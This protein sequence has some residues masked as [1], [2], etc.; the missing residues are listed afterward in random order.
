VSHKPA[1]LGAGIA[2]RKALAMRTQVTVEQFLKDRKRALN[3]AYDRRAAAGNPE[4][5]IIVD[6]GQ[7]II[8]DLCYT[9]IDTPLITIVNDSHVYCQKCY[10]EI[11][12]DIIF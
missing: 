8:C 12:K 4:N 3:E 11:D 1:I 10:D 2:F 5:W 9:S 7:E 6:A